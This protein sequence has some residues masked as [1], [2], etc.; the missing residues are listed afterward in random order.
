M[1]EIQ[2]F[3]GFPSYYRKYLCNFAANIGG[4]YHFL[5]KGLEFNVIKEGDDYWDR[6]KQ[7]QTSAPVLV[8]PDFEKPFIV[9]LDASF[10]GLGAALHQIKLIDGQR[11]NGP[12]D[13]HQNFGEVYLS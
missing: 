6:F 12:V 8:H 11:F 2:P 1:L 10:F 4:L 7:I 5:T 13:L 3:L 9:C